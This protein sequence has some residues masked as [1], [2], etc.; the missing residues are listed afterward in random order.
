MAA[1]AAGRSARIGRTSEYLAG[2]QAR[3]TRWLDTIDS[4]SQVAQQ[5]VDQRNQ[6]RSGPPA[7]RTPPP[8][9]RTF[10]QP[11][12][13]PLIVL[14]DPPEAGGGS[15][16]SSCW[17]LATRPSSQAT[18][19]AARTG[20]WPTL[21]SAK[22]RRRRAR[23]ATARRSC[24][25]LRTAA[26]VHRRTEVGHA[27]SCARRS[28][29]WCFNLERPRDGT[30]A[31]NHTI[32]YPTQE[33]QEVFWIAKRTDH[34]TV[35]TTPVRHLGEA[36]D[37]VAKSP[38]A[39]CCGDRE[40]VGSYGSVEETQASAREPHT[41]VQPTE[42]P[43]ARARARSESEPLRGAM[44]LK[45]RAQ[46]V[47]AFAALCSL[48]LVPSVADAQASNAAR[49][50]AR[51]AIK[52][53][54]AQA[55]ARHRHAR[56]LPGERRWHA[57]RRQAGQ[58][59]L[60]GLRDE[61][62]LRDSGVH[63]TWQ[64]LQTQEPRRGWTSK[65][66]PSACGSCSSTAPR[67]G[68]TIRAASPTKT[69]NRSDWRARSTACSRF[70]GPGSAEPDALLGTPRQ[71]P[72]RSRGRHRGRC[73]AAGGSESLP[74]RRRALLRSR[75]S[76]LRRAWRRFASARPSSSS[77]RTASRPAALRSSP[78]WRPSLSVSTA[79]CCRTTRWSAL[80]SVRR[81]SMSRFCRSRFLRLQSP[82]T[83]RFKAEVCLG[84]QCRSHATTFVVQR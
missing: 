28:S 11:R 62:L 71:G 44:E 84:D 69:S 78:L 22:A 53:V 75:A 55:Q 19:R 30:V 4:L 12:S 45:R 41:A 82:G 34:S 68:F 63:E 2:A 15:A 51:D 27:R 18:A 21:R 64:L 47:F 48:W 6:S 72:A 67:F 5:F 73:T 83:Y 79:S 58:G 32:S 35:L 81:G 29:E 42:A 9:S 76:L 49:K 61:A 52:P 43:A 26:F 10:A 17:S 8:G 36:A 80:S 74:C 65:S 37:G 31:R 50:K 54:D 66:T 33:H 14:D 46:P 39:E 16:A 38:R 24:L 1:A 59:D 3:R 56:P 13:K 70:H 23:S 77:S 57:D 40:L 25:A 20:A 60:H 7:N